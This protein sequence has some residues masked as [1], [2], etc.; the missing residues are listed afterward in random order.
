V[1]SLI[2]PVYRNEGSIAELIEVLDALAAQL[3][4]PLEVVFVVDGSPDDCMSLLANALPCTRFASQLIVLS[5]NF[6][7][8]AAIRE[9][10]RH[11]RGEF[12]A[13]MAADLQEPPELALQFFHTLATEPVDVVLGTRTVRA[14]GALDRLASRLFWGTYRRFVQPD[15]PA[16]GVDVFGCNR[17]FRDRLLALE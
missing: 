12:F 14:D 8:F 10:L 4:A 9:G 7:A 5:R 17:A 3:A 2:I 11:A 1:N 15:I 13:V 16:G 6:G